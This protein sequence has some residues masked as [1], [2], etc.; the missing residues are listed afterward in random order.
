MRLVFRPLSVFLSAILVAGSLIQAQDIDSADALPGP[1]ELHIRVVEGERTPAEAGKL[2]R[3]PISIAVTDDHD[4]P[5]PS[6]TVLF[7]LPAEAPTGVFSDGS[8][9]SLLYTDMQGRATVSSIQWGSQPGTA[10]IRITASKGSAH[11][12]LLLERVLTVSGKS[13][14][15]ARSADAAQPGQPKQ[16]SPEKPALVASATPAVIPP[17]TPSE[18]PSV[19]INNSPDR[20]V[21]GASGKSHKWLWI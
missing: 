6:A 12:G 15:G 11:A 16:V 13:A 9:V 14:G 3:Q 8:R 4:T 2:S 7:R 5:V 20:Q 18:P 1:K 19:V 17:S 21:T 10:V